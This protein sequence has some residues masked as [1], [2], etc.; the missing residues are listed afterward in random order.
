MPF[1]KKKKKEEEQEQEEEQE[2]VHEATLV[3][4]PTQTVPAFKLENGDVV[5]L[6]DFLLKI[7]NR[8]LH[9]EKRVV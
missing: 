5:D 7:Y 2:E 1:M 8:L 3:D 9:L 6:N 4:V